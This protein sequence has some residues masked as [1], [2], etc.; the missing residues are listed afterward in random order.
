MKLPVGTIGRKHFAAYYGG[1]LVLKIVAAGLSIWALQ[2]YGLS[3]RPILWIQFFQWTSFDLLLWRHYLQR[4]RDVEV[5]PL[6]LF[7]IYMGDS[8]WVSMFG[9]MFGLGFTGSPSPNAEGSEPELFFLDRLFSTTGFFT[10]SFLSFIW[11]AAIFLRVFLLCK[12]GE[13]HADA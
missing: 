1:V 6:C 13:S 12:K 3:V 4:M 2:R 7:L 9:F 10:T 5:S 11:I 8:F